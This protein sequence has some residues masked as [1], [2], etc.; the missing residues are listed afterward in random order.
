M[1]RVLLLGATGRLGSLIGKAL[2]ERGAQ[3]R[4]LVR[5]ESAGKVPG[6]LAGVEV[7]TEES[8]AFDGVDAVLSAVQGGPETMIDAQ[9]R[10]L[11]AAR[12]AGVRQ[13][14]PS[15]FSFDF[16]GLG[17]GE[18]VNSDWRRAFAREAASEA[19]AVE[20]VHVLNGCFLDHGV[21]FGFLGAIDLQKRQAYLWGDGEQKM[22]FT[23]YADTA[24][25]TAE[26]ALDE[27]PLAGKFA[28]AG[29]SL[30]F[31]EL[32]K[33]VEAGAGLALTVVKCGSLEEL[34]V[35]I[36]KAQAEQPG[37]LFAWLPMMYWRGILNGKGRLTGLR[38]SEYPS[39][40]PLRVRE[41]LAQNV[42][43]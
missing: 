2:V 25:F 4:L 34:D 22:D 19:G 7:V 23:T 36:A 41:Y 17:E 11:R 10:W 12:Q 40:K 8:G 18:N 37:N 26:A 38:N 13:F 24:A 42:L 31:Q 6:A 3:L 1:K 39:V 21:L 15:D 33:E 16:F 32:V 14:I 30:T 28:V 27:R 35:A 5:P 43:G 29:E 20:V 9:L